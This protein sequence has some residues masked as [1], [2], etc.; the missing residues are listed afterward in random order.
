VVIEHWTIAG[1]VAF[2]LG[3]N[4]AIAEQIDTEHLFGFTIGTDIGDAL[5]IT[6]RELIE[7]AL[8]VFGALGCRWLAHGAS[9]RRVGQ[10]L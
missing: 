10:L 3:S 7:Q 9:V 4:V 5:A 1:V 6:R 8:A 2:S